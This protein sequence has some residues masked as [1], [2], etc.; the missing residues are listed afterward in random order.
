MKNSYH[1]VHKCL[2]HGAASVPK[3]EPFF[4]QKSNLGAI[5]LHSFNHLTLSHTQ[6]CDFFYS[7][8]V[9]NTILLST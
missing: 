9:G 4:S 1:G 5:C 6:K 7:D 3:L 8:I 2:M